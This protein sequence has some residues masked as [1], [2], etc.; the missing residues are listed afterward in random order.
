MTLLM[1]ALLAGFPDG[2][3]YPKIDQII[4]L[5]LIATAATGLLSQWLFKLGAKL[6]DWILMIAIVGGATGFVVWLSF[7]GFLVGNEFVGGYLAMIC[8]QTAM[9]AFIGN[10]LSQNR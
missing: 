8:W 6:E 4:S 10:A 7:A 3:G 5:T 2:A 1:G 9:S